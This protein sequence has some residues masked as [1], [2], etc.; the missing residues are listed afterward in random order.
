MYLPPLCGLL[1]ALTRTI[2]AISPKGGGTFVI[3][4]SEV[5]SRAYILVTSS[6]WGSCSNEDSD[7]IRSDGRTL[8]SFFFFFSSSGGEDEIQDHEPAKHSP[9]PRVSSLRHSS[10]AAAGPWGS[11]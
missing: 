4:I 8:D 3:L 10:R 2:F 11:E 9:A 7:S 5:L 1:G 6:I